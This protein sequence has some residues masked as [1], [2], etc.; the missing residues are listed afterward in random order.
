MFYDLQLILSFKKCVICITPC[1]TVLENKASTGF[2]PWYHI[3]SM[4][5]SRPFTRICLD[6]KKTHGC[7]NGGSI[8]TEWED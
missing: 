7:L 5:I 4:P 3:V 8:A 1:V 2:F 6:M